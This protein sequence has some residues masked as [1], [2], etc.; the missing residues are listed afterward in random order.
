MNKNP[1]N[2]TALFNIGYSFYLQGKSTE[3]IF[4]LGSY[5]R[6]Y[7][8]DSSSYYLLGRIYERMEK[9]DKAITYYNL[10]LK[11]EPSNYD[12][13]IHLASIYFLNK[14]NRLKNKFLV[15]SVKN[16][17]FDQNKLFG[18]KLFRMIIFYKG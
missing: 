18:D 1:L 4:Y 7:P 15:S 2:I 6:R 12:S 13:Q 3:A 9:F 17:E 14:Q 11:F 5:I 10:S 16:L 8:F